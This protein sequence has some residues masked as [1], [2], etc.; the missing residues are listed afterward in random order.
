MMQARA[1]YEMRSIGLRQSKID[2]T[3]SFFAVRES[4]VRIISL[5]KANRRESKRYEKEIQD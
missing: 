5:R 2:C 1:D 4:A 3:S